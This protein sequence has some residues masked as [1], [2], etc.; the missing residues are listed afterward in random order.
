MLACVPANRAAEPGSLVINVDR[1]S[2]DG[3][4]ADEPSI[5]YLP[6]HYKDGPYILV[7]LSRISAEAI[8]DLLI[9]AHRRAVSKPARRT[10]AR[11]ARPR[12]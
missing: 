3:L 10:V 9:A 4:L 12:R 6:D 2:R 5:Y 8:R 7:R 1:E 11:R